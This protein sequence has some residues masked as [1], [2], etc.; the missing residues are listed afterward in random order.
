MQSCNLADALCYLN[1]S[2]NAVL[3][4]EI[5]Q[6]APAQRSAF[7]LSTAH[8]LAALLAAYDFAH[9]HV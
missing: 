6:Q 5:K 7:H 8:S 4:P 2:V 9:E 1:P 3:N